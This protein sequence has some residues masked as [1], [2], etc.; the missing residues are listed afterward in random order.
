M[1]NGI[2]ST[3]CV[4]GEENFVSFLCCGDHNVAQRQVGVRNRI[5][6]Y[7]KVSSALTPNAKKGSKPLKKESSLQKVENSNPHLV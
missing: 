6:L 3:C 1:D 5:A 7:E 4:E 2:R